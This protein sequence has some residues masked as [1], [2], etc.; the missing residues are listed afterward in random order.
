MDPVTPDAAPS[1]RNRRLPILLLVGV[2]IAAAAWTAIWSV[3]RGRILTE[4]DARIAVA[5]EHGVRIA[6]ADRAI[7]GFPFRMELTCRDPGVEVAV[8]GLTASAAALRVV[9]QVWD[10]RLI[11]VEIDG[12]GGVRDPGGEVAGKWRSL[13]ASLRWTTSDIGRVSVAAEG[14][15]L[16]T[17]QGARPPLHLVAAHAEAHGRP[18]VSE[19]D[20]DLA[21]AFAAASLAE[22]DKRIGPPTSDLSLAATLVDFLPPGPG[23]ALPAFAERG[24]RIEPVSL[25]FATGGVSVEGAGALTLGRDGLLDGMV[26]LT[27]RGLEA[28]AGGGAKGLGPELTTALSGFVL[29]G[30]ASGDPAR[31]GRRLDLV[32][33][34]GAARIARLSL[35]RIPQLFRPAE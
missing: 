35:G 34:G 25:T 3:G 20:L 29:L 23:P 13:R 12:P 27:A 4:I 2:A 18:G 33:D 28:L 14:L 24:G 32:I 26:A 11:L 6:C 19:R 9:A 1:R 8:R 22:G 5:A 17:K 10:P 21:V 30:K 7:G 31:P 15:D 16:T